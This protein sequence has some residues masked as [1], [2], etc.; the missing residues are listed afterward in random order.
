MYVMSQRT[1]L[2]QSEASRVVGQLKGNQSQA[3]VATA[4]LVAQSV[5]SR[6]WYR[7]LETDMQAKDRDKVAD[8]QQSQRKIVI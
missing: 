3:D 7:F 4:I 2:A 1:H 5:I 8:V 6:I